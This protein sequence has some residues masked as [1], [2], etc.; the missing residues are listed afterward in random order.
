MSQAN[1]S[2]NWVCWP[3]PPMLMVPQSLPLERPVVQPPQSHQKNGS[4]DKKQAIKT[5]KNLKFLLQKMRKQSDVNNLGR[6]V[7]LKR[8]VERH[9]PHLETRDGISIVK[10][11]LNFKILKI[12][13]MLGRID[14]GH[15]PLEESTSTWPCRSASSSAIRGVV[16]SR[17][18]WKP[19]THWISCSLIAPPIPPFPGYA[20]AKPS[21][22]SFSFAV[23]VVIISAKPNSPKVVGEEDVPIEVQNGGSAVKKESNPASPVD[24]PTD[25]HIT[26]FPALEDIF[27]GSEG[28][29]WA[30]L[31]I[32]G[33]EN[34][35]PQAG[36]MSVES[37]SQA[38]VESFVPQL[39]LMKTQAPFILRGGDSV[40]VEHVKLL[41]FSTTTPNKIFLDLF[42]AIMD[43][44]GEL[45][46]LH[47]MSGNTTE[48]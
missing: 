47:D 20:K 9:L 38:G 13:F 16:K 21:I 18:M 4:T 17:C 45:N 11:L 12:F 41:F 36:G 19:R 40:P 30:L 31:V 7:L 23:E 48:G 39:T 2:G 26:M 42:V 15:A 8:E 3:S 1:N 32:F 22:L 35:A 25:A 43:F 46:I 28:S 44:A 5:E 27:P 6:I 37:P 14:P 29:S 10:S 24:S 34:L 33:E